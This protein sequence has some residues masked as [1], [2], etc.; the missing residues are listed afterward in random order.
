MTNDPLLYK[1]MMSLRDW[2]RDCWCSPGEVNTCGMRFSYQLGNLPFGYDHKYT[3]SHMGY[4]LRMTDIQAAIGCAQFNKLNDFIKKRKE[5]F[6]LLRQKLGKYAEY[7]QLPDPFDDS[8]PAWFG[9]LMTVRPNDKFVKLDLIKHLEDAHIDTRPL[10]AGNILRHPTFTE[11]DYILRISD[12]FKL[13]S[14]DLNEG[15]YQMLPNTDIIMNNSFWIGL[16]PGIEKEDIDYIAEEF[17]KFFV[18]R[19]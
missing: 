8:D 5:N 12:S 11:N 18:L 1:I 3:Y 7:V 15:H 4:N 9:F 10:F 6:N 13:S 17:E 19:A 14:K 16:W 2:G